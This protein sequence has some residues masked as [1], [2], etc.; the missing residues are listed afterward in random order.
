MKYIVKKLSQSIIKKM[1]LGIAVL[2]ITFSAWAVTLDQAKQQGLVGEMS[3]GYLGV[4]VPS[5]EVKILVD[6]V[7]KKRKNIYINLARKN[8]IT[9]QQITALA[10]EKSLSKTQPGHYI[11][12]AS[13]EWTKK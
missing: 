3:N 11:K 5:S 2:S 4:V 1:S 8:N 7:N 10:G 9:M 13:G 12:R 6:D